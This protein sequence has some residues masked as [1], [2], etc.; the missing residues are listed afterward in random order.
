MTNVT[1]LENMKKFNKN[2]SGDVMGV[3]RT[4]FPTIEVDELLP[5]K[6]RKK[7]L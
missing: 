7:K 6:K 2:H 1:T 5:E 3:I 4:F